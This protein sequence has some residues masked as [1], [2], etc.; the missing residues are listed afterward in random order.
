VDRSD[1]LLRRPE[2]RLLLRIAVLGIGVGSLLIFVSWKLT[3]PRG[4]WVRV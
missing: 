3:R 2:A 4:W 1:D